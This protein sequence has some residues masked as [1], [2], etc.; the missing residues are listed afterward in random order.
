MHIG[1]FACT[2]AGTIFCK[3]PIHSGPAPKPCAPSWTTASRW[4]Q[5][6]SDNSF[7]LLEPNDFRSFYRAFDTIS[8]N[9]KV[10]IIAEG[11]PLTPDLTKEGAELLAKHYVGNKKVRTEDAIAVVAR[12]YDYQAVR[13]SG[14]LY[15]LVKRYTATGDLPFITFEEAEQALRNI[16]RTT[17]E[18]CPRTIPKSGPD[19]PL[20]RLA[21]ASNPDD[22]A[23]LA[24]GVP[25]SQLAP[26]LRRQAWLLGCQSYLG[27]TLNVVGRSYDNLL[28]MR[29][30]KAR[31]L[32][33]DEE[34]RRLSSF[35]TTFGYEGPFGP[36][37]TQKFVPLSHGFK[38]NAGGAV[39]SHIPAVLDAQGRPTLPP[40]GLP[41]P[42]APPPMPVQHDTLADGANRFALSATADHVEP[43]RATIER[44]NARGASFQASVSD[45]LAAKTVCVFDADL[46]P[47]QPIL[48]GLADIYGLEI[49]PQQNGSLFL[50]QPVPRRLTDFGRLPSEILRLLPSPLLRAITGIAQA[51]AATQT[52]ETPPIVLRNV[53][54]FRRGPSLPI[55]SETEADTL[56]KAAVIRLRVVVQHRVTPEQGG[57]LTISESGDEPR[58]LLALTHLANCYP[59]LRQVAG[60]PV[61]PYIANF[62]RASLQINLRGLEG[63]QRSEVT[64]VFGHKTPDGSFRGSTIET[65]TVNRG[66]PH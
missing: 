43:L 15:L 30:P 52:R 1:V 17:D 41:D 10:T 29:D 50:T 18:L 35:V 16:L 2:V 9:A 37:G 44:L 40:S 32:W 7:I 61:P 64:Y 34:L 20:E 57:Y 58:R 42:T 48:R 47:P 31:F 46:A 51:E 59:A 55:L 66:V 60:E 24:S 56:Y 14:T 38:L 26:E 36:R 28:G 12:A 25:V 49:V 13:V 11:T 22:R 63:G 53:E 23:R 21:F 5:P 33:R 27:L 45:A 19:A 39:L 4:E 6:Q 3:L 54:E 65:T 8:R 62:D